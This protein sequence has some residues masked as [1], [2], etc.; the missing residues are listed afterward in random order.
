MLIIDSTVWVDYFNGVENRQTDYL[1]PIVD[2]PPI[3][4]SDLTLAEVL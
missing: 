2:K 1:H 3:L 4:I